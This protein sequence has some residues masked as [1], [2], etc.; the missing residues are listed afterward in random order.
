LK[1]TWGLRVSNSTVTNNG[2]GLS[3]GGPGGVLL[4]RGNN[5]VEGNGTDTSRTIGSYT[6]K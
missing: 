5:T 2:T 4:S 3:Q 6:A 1:Y